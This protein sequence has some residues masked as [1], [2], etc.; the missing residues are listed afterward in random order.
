[1]PSYETEREG[2]IAF[3][4]SFLPLINPKVSNVNTANF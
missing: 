1:M 3:Y 4:E 2:Q